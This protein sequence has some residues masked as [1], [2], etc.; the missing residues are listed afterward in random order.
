MKERTGER[1]VESG[2]AK[3]KGSSKTI[4]GRFVS[5]FHH[6]VEDDAGSVLSFVVKYLRGLDRAHIPKMGLP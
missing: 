6:F 1:D 4:S 5:L 3:E 2:N